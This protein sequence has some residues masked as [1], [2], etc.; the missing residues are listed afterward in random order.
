MVGALDSPIHG[1]PIYLGRPYGGKNPQPR[2]NE[3]YDYIQ[4]GGATGKV[5]SATPH[6]IARY[7]RMLDDK[8]L[9]EK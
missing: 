7:A 5:I 9:P 2:I 3:Y 6:T 8:G 4:K 1:S